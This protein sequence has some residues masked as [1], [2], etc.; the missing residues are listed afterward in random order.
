VLV[1]KYILDNIAMENH[2][3]FGNFWFTFNS[4]PALYFVPLT[5]DNA[6]LAKPV[7]NG[8]VIYP[9]VSKQNL[10]FGTGDRNASCA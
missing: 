9:K 2:D 10:I 7:W 1:P 4:V 6:T 8:I 3:S 5:H